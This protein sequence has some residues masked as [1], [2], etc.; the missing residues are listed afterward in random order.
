MLLYLYFNKVLLN[1]NKPQS[2]NQSSKQLINQSLLLSIFSEGTDWHAEG[3][4]AY[5][6][7]EFSVRA[8]TDQGHGPYSQQIRCKTQE[9][10]K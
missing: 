2:I 10:R 6:T 4:S 3:L 7:Y 9:G 1:P 8:N 5:T